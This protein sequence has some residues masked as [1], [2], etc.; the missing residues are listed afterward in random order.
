MSYIVLLLGGAALD[1]KV[2]ASRVSERRNKEL[3]LP[4]QPESSPHLGDWIR[5]DHHVASFSVPVPTPVA[6][7]GKEGVVLRKI[8]GI[9]WIGRTKTPQTPGL[10]PP[11]TQ[12]EFLM[13]LKVSRV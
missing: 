2:P 11:L 6:A 9:L 13:G 3:P 1:L 10:N 12:E 8:Q 7:A 5:L 4:H